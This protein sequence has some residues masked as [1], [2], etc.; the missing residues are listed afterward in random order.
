MQAT[1]HHFDPDTRSGSVVTDDGEL[2]HFDASAFDTSPLHQLRPG[3]RL[4]VTVAGAGKDAKVTGLALGT[5]GVVPA[6][7]SRP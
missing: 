6:K 7:P 3:Q 4:T 5:V 1:A 2:L